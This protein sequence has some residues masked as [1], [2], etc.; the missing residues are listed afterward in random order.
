MP[1]CEGRS[2]LPARRVSSTA[3]AAIF[4]GR[5]MSGIRTRGNLGRSYTLVPGYA[6]KL[7]ALL[8]PFGPAMSQNYQWSL[9]LIQHSTCDLAN[10]SEILARAPLHHGP[11]AK[12]D[13]HDTRGHPR[14]GP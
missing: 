10:P 12:Q 14:A 1:P 8:E 2:Q 7:N 5:S 11:Q 9:N 6:A 3:L 4:P 13:R